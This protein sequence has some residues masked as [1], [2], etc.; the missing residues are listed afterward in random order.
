MQTEILGDFKIIPEEL[1]SEKISGVNSS[2]M[3]SL[4]IFAIVFFILLLLVAVYLVLKFF[5]DRVNG[6]LLKVYLNLKK[7]LF[8]DSII[9]YMI[10]SNLELTWQN[11]MFVATMASYDT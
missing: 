5:K 1:E 7:T 6:L 2:L 8:F 9:R 4:G 11:M 10:E 3:V